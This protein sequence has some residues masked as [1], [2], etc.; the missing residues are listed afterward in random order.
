MPP[1]PPAPPSID[2]EVLTLV[3]APSGSASP[4]TFTGVLRGQANTIPA[5]HANLA[6]VNL[7]PTDTW[8]M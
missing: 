3:N 4:Q 8:S 6:P 2:D 1:V 5:A 7:Y